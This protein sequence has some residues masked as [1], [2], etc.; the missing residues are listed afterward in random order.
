[1]MACANAMML[2]VRINRRQVTFVTQY[3]AQ[4]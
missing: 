4:R 2:I 1:M 3:L